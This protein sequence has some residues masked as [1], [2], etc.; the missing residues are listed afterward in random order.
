MSATPS[1]AGP[2]KAGPQNLIGADELA[3]AIK[4]AIEGIKKKPGLMKSTVGYM[5]LVHKYVDRIV[6][7]K[8]QGKWVATHGTQ[9]PL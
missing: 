3:K 1:P 7:A 8:D 9:Q 2:T 4:V 6:T 5:E